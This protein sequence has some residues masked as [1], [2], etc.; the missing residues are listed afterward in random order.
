M[1]ACTDIGTPVSFIKQ[2]V[3][4]CALIVRVPRLACIESVTVT[5]GLHR[6]VLHIKA[7][8]H[9][10]MRSLRQRH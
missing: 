4:A 6:V 9:V 7:A 10:H 3:R 5:V 8:G 2:G 1:Q